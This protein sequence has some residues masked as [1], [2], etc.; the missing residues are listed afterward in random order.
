[1]DLALQGRPCG[2]Q[3]NREVDAVRGRF[4][5]REKQDEGIPDDLVFR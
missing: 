3:H 5:P 2:Q 4:V 1:L